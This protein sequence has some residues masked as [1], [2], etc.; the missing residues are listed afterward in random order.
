MLP[1][2]GERRGAGSGGGSG[3][4]SPGSYSILVDGDDMTGP[5]ADDA[6][7]HPRRASS[8]RAGCAEGITPGV[9]RAGLV[10]PR[11]DDV[12]DPGSPGSAPLIP[13]ARQVQS[14]V[15]GPGADRRNTRRLGTGRGRSDPVPGRRSTTCCAW[16]QGRTVARAQV[17]ASF[18]QARGRMVKDR[19]QAG[20][21]S[22]GCRTAGVT[23]RLRRKG[24]I[25]RGFRFQ[26]QPVL[27]TARRQGGVNSSARWR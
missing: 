14:E 22:R 23:L 5:I 9:G 6:A 21:R 13:A 20:R 10:S 3:V 26:L 4:R 8:C 25:A 1:R 24:K 17:K 19:G 11:G 27:E 7:R 2:T 18:E 16:E 12:T 15:E